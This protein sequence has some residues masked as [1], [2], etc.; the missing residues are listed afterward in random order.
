MATLG[1]FGLGSRGNA[2]LGRARLGWVRQLM[3]RRGRQARVAFAFRD[4]QD[5]F[6]TD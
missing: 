4:D 5:D 2:G 6:L 3:V 1:Q